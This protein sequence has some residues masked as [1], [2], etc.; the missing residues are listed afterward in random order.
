MRANC[1]L[2]DHVVLAL[3]LMRI[4]HRFDYAKIDID[5]DPELAGRYGLRIPVLLDGELEICAGQCDPAV[6][7]SYLGERSGQ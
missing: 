7:E 1:T 3:E 6:I 2:C 5:A 4:R